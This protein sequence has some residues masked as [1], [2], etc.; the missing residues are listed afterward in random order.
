MTA[1]PARCAECRQPI[2]APRRGADCRAPVHQG[3]QG[4]HTCAPKRARVAALEAE[5]AA[6]LVR[7][8]VVLTLEI[9]AARGSPHS[10]DWSTCLGLR[11]PERIVVEV[12]RAHGGAGD[13]EHPEG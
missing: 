11:A 13:P 9:D 2:R 12:T 6:R 5:T 8:R 1:P 10:W 3:C 7:H 4:R